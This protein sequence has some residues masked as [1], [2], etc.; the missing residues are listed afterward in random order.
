MCLSV[1]VC[2][3][4]CLSV[5]TVSGGVL[6]EDALSVHAGKDFTLMRTANGKVTGTVARLSVCLSVCLSQ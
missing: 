1:Y 2:V 5:C 4:V 6:D 3:C